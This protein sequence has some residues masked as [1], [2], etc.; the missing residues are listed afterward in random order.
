M[1]KLF[2][3]RTVFRVKSMKP[4]LLWEVTVD[5]ANFSENFDVSTITAQ[6]IVG[7]VNVS[8]LKMIAA[9]C[10]SSKGFHFLKEFI[11]KI[12]SYVS[13]LSRH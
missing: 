5:L 8:K 13:S 6:A 3:F 7:Q 4:L 10:K 9:T 12:D 1:L 2:T 11:T